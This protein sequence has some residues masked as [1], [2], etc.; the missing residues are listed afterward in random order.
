MQTP[1][2]GIERNAQ[3]VLHAFDALLDP[4]GAN[5]L[6]LDDLAEKVAKPLTQL[7][8]RPRPLDATGFATPAHRDLRLHHEGSV[9]RGRQLDVG[10][11]SEHAN[12]DRDAV[13]GEQFLGVMLKQ[14][15]EARLSFGSDSNER[16]QPFSRQRSDRMVRPRWSCSA[17]GLVSRVYRPRRGGGW[18]GFSIHVVPRSTAVSTKI[19]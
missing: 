18:H 3:I 4:A 15:H 7:R 11:G 9:E 8:G 12:R 16:M 1:L 2:A 14:H 5:R 6:A 17:A 10:C 13:G 19:K